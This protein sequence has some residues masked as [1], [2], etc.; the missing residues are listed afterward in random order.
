MLERPSHPN[1]RN[2][3]RSHGGDQVLFRYSALPRF[4]TT[5]TE[6]E[7]AYSRSASLPNHRNQQQSP[8]KLGV[9]FHVDAWRAYEMA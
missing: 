1:F 5:R 7:Q 6:I 2:S 9:A 4:E 8:C 3:K